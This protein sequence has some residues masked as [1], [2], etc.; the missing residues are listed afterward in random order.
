MIFSFSH[1]SV[2]VRSCARA[3]SE[4]LVCDS[5]DSE[6]RLLPLYVIA[7]WAAATTSSSLLFATA[8][9]TCCSS[10]MRLYVERALAPVM[11]REVAVDKLGGG[12]WHHALRIGLSQR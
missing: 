8:M 12:R 10:S 11:S 4:G 2:V 7:V 5:H 6:E 1:V 9:A 3:F